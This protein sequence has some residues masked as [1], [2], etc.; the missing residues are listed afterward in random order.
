MG[1]HTRQQEATVTQELFSHSSDFSYVQAI[2]MLEHEL[3]GSA[4][5]TK[6]R[7]RPRL[8]LDFPHSDIVEITKDEEFVTL[9][10]TFLGLY[11]ES[12]PL[13][14]FYTEELLDEAR[15]EKSVMRD[16]IDI[17]NIPIYQAYFKVWLKNQLGVRLN[18]FH[19]E[20]VLE[21]LHVFSG[22]PY[23]HTRAKFQ[24]DHNLLKY[25]GLNMHF[26]RSAEALRILVSDI[27]GSTDVEIVQCVEQMAEIPK[28]QYCH[29]GIENSTLGDNLHLGSKIKDRMGKFRIEID[30]LNMN[31]F[32]LLL[33]GAKKF[34]SLVKTAKLYIGEGLSWDLQLTLKA[35]EKEEIVLGEEQHAKLGLNSWLGCSK[36]PRRLFLH[37]INRGWN[38]DS[39]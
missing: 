4:L 29:L 8:S 27:V 3:R 5:R 34:N 12:S 33:P 11:G 14:T 24:D 2:R 18:E 35:Q 10:V 16:F 26:P 23:A 19:D 31:E 20:K 9:V 38:H 6:I 30:N 1:T 25:A 15:D 39:Q 36:E 13:P 21:L 32:N 28:A 7:T 37:N 17:F 22:M